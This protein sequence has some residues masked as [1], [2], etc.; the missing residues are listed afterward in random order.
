MRVILVAL[1]FPLDGCDL[2]AQ[3]ID[4]GPRPLKL[5]LQ[6][7]DAPLLLHQEASTQREF[8]LELCLSAQRDGRVLLHVTASLGGSLELL[9]SWRCV[10][11]LHVS[12]CSLRHRGQL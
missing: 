2:G 1:A 6:L 5:V 10:H 4:L 7:H 9:A 8:E 12:P 3:P 11:A